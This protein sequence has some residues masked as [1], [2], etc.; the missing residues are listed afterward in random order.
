MQA[1][2]A[3]MQPRNR[4]ELISHY[5]LR[6]SVAGLAAYLLFFVFAILMHGPVRRGFGALPG[7]AFWGGIPIS[8][9]L[10][11]VGFFIRDRKASIKTMLLAVPMGILWFFAALSSF[12]LLWG[13]ASCASC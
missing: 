8:I 3:I 5:L 1:E 7:I 9:A 10:F 6:L 12:A 2:I 13:S 11:A 4:A